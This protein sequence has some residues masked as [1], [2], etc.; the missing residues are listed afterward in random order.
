MRALAHMIGACLLSFVG[1]GFLLASFNP[2]TWPWDA[3]AWCL[4]VA[5]VLWLFAGD[6]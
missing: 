2:T 6:A 1:F 5:V 3:R 4:I